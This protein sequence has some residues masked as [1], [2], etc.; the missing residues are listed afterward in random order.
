MPPRPGTYLGFDP[1]ERRLG[2]AVG[3]TLTGH[4]RALRTLR[5]RAGEPDWDELDA[6]LAEWQP[7]GAV[8]GIPR[9]ADGSASHSTRLAER[10]AGRLGSRSGLPVHRIDERLSSREAA[11]AL[12]ARGRRSAA[13]DAEAAR[14]ILETWL[15]E[16]CP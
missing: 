6:L 4:A 15:S 9:H 7:A 5:C 14:V 13:L 2:A 12:Q 1:G 3:E 8:V 10:F 11:A 16:H